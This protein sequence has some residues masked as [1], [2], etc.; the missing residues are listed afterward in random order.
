MALI[1]LLLLAHF[2]VF[3]QVSYLTNFFI[4]LYLRLGEVKVRCKEKLASFL[5]GRTGDLDCDIFLFSTNW[6]FWIFKTSQ[7]FWATLDIRTSRPPWTS[8][9]FQKKTALEILAIIFREWYE[10]NLC[11]CFYVG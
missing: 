1:F 3:F 9:T 10:L 2:F 7:T 6:K 8:T 5:S 11:D 4:T